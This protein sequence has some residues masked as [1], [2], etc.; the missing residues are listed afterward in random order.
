MCTNPA[1]RHN[2]VPLRPPQRSGPVMPESADEARRASDDTREDALELLAKAASLWAD[3]GVEGGSTA[4]PAEPGAPGSPG[5]GVGARI[6]FLPAYYRRVAPEDLIAAGPDRLGE[7]VGRHAALGASR[8]QGR[9]AVGVRP[10]QAS[11]GAGPTGPP[12]PATSRSASRG[13][14]SNSAR[15]QTSSDWPR[16]CAASWMTCGSRWR[17]SGGCAGP[18]GNSSRC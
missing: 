6:A 2:D 18:P 13:S 10:A 7:T 3:G 12:W 9:P 15:W 4:P 1:P 8:P 11:G 16:I 5:P 14:T 17:T